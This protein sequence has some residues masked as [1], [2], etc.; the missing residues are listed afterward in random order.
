MSGDLRD[1]FRSPKGTHDLLPPQSA[2]WE[3]LIG[4][5]R[6][7]VTAAAYGLI[8]QP[9]FEHVEVFRRVGEGTDMVQKEMYEFTDRGNRAL[10]L[11]PEGTAAV[12]RAFVQHRP[13]VPWKV[14]YVAPHFRYERAQKGRYRQHHQL[15]IEAIGTDDPALDVEVIALAAEFFQDLGLR[16][17]GLLLNSL[18]D[19]ACRPAYIELLRGYLADHEAELCEDSQ[20]RYETNPLRVLDCKQPQCRA[21][22]ERAPQ[23]FDHLCDPCREHFEVVQH[24]LDS[25]GVK[26][27]IAPRLVRGLDYYTRT[28]F[29]FQSGALDAAQNALGGGGRYDPLS[30]EMGGPQA[31]GIGFG[32]GVERLLIA[33]DAEGV[34]ATPETC[35]DAFVVDAV[36]A[37]QGSATVAM[38]IID[39]LRRAGLSADRAYGGRSVKAQ[40]KMADRSRAPYAVMV[41]P[42]ELRRGVVVVKDMLSGEQV[43]V[44]RD[45]VSG[46]LRS[47]L[48]RLGGAGAAEIT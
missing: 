16:G 36:G 34:F 25:L 6:K 9:V 47:R 22:T 43:E 39:D 28:T 37:Q 2:R 26:F 40:W 45:D 17:V 42:E 21:V 35:V 13:P 23:L 15:G 46:W 14:W 3:A 38:V 12:M 11:R 31:P 24:G 20:A 18:G 33:C 27:E 19:E 32:I 41:A 8:V 10:V 5:F 48:E 44:E 29:E 4:Q 1:A 7:R 30:E